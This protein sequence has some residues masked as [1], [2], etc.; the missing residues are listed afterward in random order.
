MQ[1]AIAWANQAAIKNE[2]GYERVV[3]LGA[4][5]GG[6]LAALATTADALPPGMG[7]SFD[8]KPAAGVALVPPIDMITWGD[9]PGQAGNPLI[10]GSFIALWGAGYASPD[11]VPLLA[12]LAAS[13]WLHVDA[14]DPPIYIGSGENDAIAPP[15]QNGNVLEQF[16]IDQGP[17]TLDAWNDVVDGQEHNIGNHLHVTRLDQFLGAVAAGSFD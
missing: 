16:Y 13:P 5:A 10:A 6:H 7:A 9:Q 12:R 1:W 3:V 4:S 11:D 15:A 8:P 17:G 2:Y 14:G